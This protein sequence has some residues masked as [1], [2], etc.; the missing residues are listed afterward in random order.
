MKEKLR[1]RTDTGRRFDEPE[2]RFAA[3]GRIFCVQILNNRAA[4]TSR[5]G[6]TSILLIKG[7]IGK[8]GQ[9]IVNSNGID[10]HKSHISSL[11]SI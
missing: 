4:C 10:S 2:R 6:R 9:T 3:D 1:M 7:W 8:D 11:T 5:E